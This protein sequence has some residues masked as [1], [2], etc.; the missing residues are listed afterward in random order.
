VEN[1]TLL[2]AIV[3]TLRGR[4]SR[5]TF[6]KVDDSDPNMGKAKEKARDT[7]ING[8]PAQLHTVIPHVF[9]LEGMKL[10]EGSQRTF[11]RHLKNRRKPPPER[12]KTTIM[13]DRTRYAAA[14]LSGRTPTDSEIWQAINHKD[15]TRTTRVFLWRTIHQAYKIG[16]YWRNKPTFEHY[17]ECRH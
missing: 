15:I 13:L 14:Q 12:L 7:P 4:G 5:C 1:N 8:Q 2:K 3:A 6:Q 16:E 11:Y 9:R 10:S 17:A